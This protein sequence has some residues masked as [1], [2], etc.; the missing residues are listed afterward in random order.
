MDIQDG[1]LR[2][3]GWMGR[4]LT[5]YLHRYSGASETSGR[6]H[7]HPWRIVTSIIVKGGYLDEVDGLPIQRNAFSMHC[8]RNSQNHRILSIEPN[9]LTFFIGLFR[10]QHTGPCY[11]EATPFGAAHYTELR[12]VNIADVPD[13][14][15]GGQKTDHEAA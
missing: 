2:R 1:F 15:G 8:Y 13:S 14:R 3:S 12:S 11:S 7:N 5:A 6:P 10:V 9:T 4:L